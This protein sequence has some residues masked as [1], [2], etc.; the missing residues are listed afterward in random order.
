MSFLAKT[1]IF[2]AVGHE[3]TALKILRNILPSQENGPAKS[4]ILSCIH[5]THL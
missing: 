5:L 2:V 4:V 3:Y 1:S